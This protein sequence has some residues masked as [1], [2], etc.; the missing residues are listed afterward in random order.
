M[1]P[2]QAVQSSRGVQ[3]MRQIRPGAM[4]FEA[5]SVFLHHCYCQGGCRHTP[6]TPICASGAHAPA[7]HGLRGCSSSLACEAADCLR[8]SW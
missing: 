2:E 1:Q 5:E 4:E 8:C 3:V 7:L 6:Y